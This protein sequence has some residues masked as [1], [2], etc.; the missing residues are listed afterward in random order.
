MKKI[1]ITLQVTPAIAKDTQGNE[2][3]ALTGHLGTH[4]DVMD[5]DFPLDYTELDAVVFDISDNGNGETA[6][7]DIDTTLIREGM[8]VAFHSHYIELE[9]YGTKEYF[10]NHPQLSQQ[11]I[12]FLVDKKV[13][14]IGI[15]F[16]GVRRG[17]EHTPADQYC[18]D[19][20]MFVIEN[21]C[22]LDMLLNGNK[23]CLFHAHTYP[24]NFAGMT[25]IPCRV[26]AEL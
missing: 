13:C 12:Q 4:F 1:D 11:L 21:L 15:D 25:G 20:G 26:V 6:L 7:S 18:A 23:S 3:K 8:F 10:H 19:N 24:M 9:D 22:H 5:K 17:C 14:I 16:A 2:K